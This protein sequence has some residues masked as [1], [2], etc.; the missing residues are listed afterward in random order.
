MKVKIIFP[1]LVAIIL[2]S[3][4]MTGCTKQEISLYFAKDIENSFYLVEESR[5]VS[6]D[7]IYKNSIQELIKGPKQ[8]GLV[9]TLP[10]T[11]KVN[12]VNIENHTAVVDFSEEIITDQGIPHSST[13]ENLAIYSI[14]N[15]LT[16][17]EEI[18]EVEITVNGKGSGTIDGMAIEDFWGHI[19][20]AQKFERNEEIIYGKD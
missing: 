7:K 2:I 10:K 17:F 3:F 14:V 4:M 15:T 11:V 16:Q 13:T 8:E 12:Y 5:Q 20:I 1:I 18:E 19:G 9:A 6:T